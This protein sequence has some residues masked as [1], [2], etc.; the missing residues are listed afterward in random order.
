MNRRFVLFFENEDDRRSH[1]NYCL[2]KV[3]IKYYN[4]MIGGK[5]FFDQTINSEL[6]VV[7]VVDLKLTFTD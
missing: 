6:K 5:T 2:P 1:S 4:V 3:T 7:R